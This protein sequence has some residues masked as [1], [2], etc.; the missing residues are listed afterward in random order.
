[1]QTSPVRLAGTGLMLNDGSAHAEFIHR[2][3]M[4]HE[5]LRDELPADHSCESF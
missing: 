5:E 2:I 4:R 1:M 3:A